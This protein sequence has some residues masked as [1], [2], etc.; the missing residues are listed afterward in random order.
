MMFFDD[1]QIE[2]SKVIS[3]LERLLGEVK[4]RVNA[5]ACILT[6]EKGLPI[7]AVGA[8]ENE[9]ERKFIPFTLYLSSLSGKLG[10]L[11]GFG[12][13]N[14]MIADGE[15][16]LVVIKCLK[17]PLPMAA[18][19]ILGKDAPLGLVLYE[20]SKL[21]KEVSRILTCESEEVK[22]SDPETLNGRDVE[23]ILDQLEKDPFL[24]TLLDSLNDGR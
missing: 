8:Q 19:I 24:K 12:K 14:L 17:K 15:T 3:Q 7:A 13:V 21:E 5:L 18:S 23:A 16:Y 11:T 6:D 10:K 2:G 20:L 1:R 9:G 4:S 22:A